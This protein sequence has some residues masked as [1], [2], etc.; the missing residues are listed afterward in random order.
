MTRDTFISGFSNLSTC[1]SGA[2]QARG[3][4][5]D[6][7]MISR[8]KLDT[9]VSALFPYINAV[10]QDAAF[11]E[12]PLFIKFIYRHCL[13]ALYP[14]KGAA[15]PFKN[16]RHAYEFT[17]QLVDYMNDIHRRK[18]TITPSY[19]KFR[20]VNVLDI[21]RLLPRNNCRAC[22]F[23][24]CM[25]FA[26][27]LSTRDT[28]PHKCPHLGRPISETAEY[29]VYDQAGN[30]LSTVTIEIDTTRTKQDLDAK[31]KQ[32]KKLEQRLTTMS[33]TRSMPEQNANDLLPA[34]LTGREL[35]VLRLMAHGATNKEISDLLG[36]SPHTSKSH[37]IHIFNKLG[38][39][40]RTQAAVWATRH[41]LV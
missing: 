6:S 20:P 19:K 35:E 18:S 30:L 12:K 15:A 11:Y 13:C 32:I 3:L 31:Q 8:F 4:N 14:D 40:D 41:H 33:R 9:D 24:T 27:A 21:L 7:C 5:A 37:V 29:P 25:A 26:A 10:A 28:T 38:V 2:P 39:G 36:I 23:K 16:Y 22:G 34:P 17:G 1:R